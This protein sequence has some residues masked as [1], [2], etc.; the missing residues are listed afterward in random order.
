ML[1]IRVGMPSVPSHFVSAISSSQPFTNAHGIASVRNQTLMFARI[2]PSFV[3]IWF[4]NP[5]S[6][7]ESVNAFHHSPQWAST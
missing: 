4:M 6:L 3:S 5:P 7:K 1:W 2:S